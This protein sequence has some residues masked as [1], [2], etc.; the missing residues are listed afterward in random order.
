[1]ASGDPDAVLRDPAVARSFLGSE[2][3]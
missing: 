3:P 2:G 1:V